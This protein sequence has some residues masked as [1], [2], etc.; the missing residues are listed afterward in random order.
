MREQTKLATCSYCGARTMLV[1]SAR[2]GHEL[3]C[4]N[5]GAPIHEMKWLKAP[6]E[7]KPRKRKVETGYVPGVHGPE[8]GTRYESRQPDMRRRKKRKKPL[9]KR[10]L[11]EAVDVL[12]DI[13]D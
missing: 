1:P 11:S 7:A 4:G 2:D 3:A 8:R 12:E 9:W 5:C 6:A 10:A 13:F